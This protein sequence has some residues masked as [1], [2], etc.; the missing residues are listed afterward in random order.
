M[1]SP[2]FNIDFDPLL[3]DGDT[4]T[5]RGAGLS[6]DGLNIR[7]VSVG[8]MPEYAEDY[9]ALTAT[10]WLE[11]QQDTNLEMNPM[12]LSQLRMRVMFDGKVRLKNSPAV[13][14]WRTMR[15]I[16]YL[17]QWSEEWPDAVA[18]FYWRASEFFVYSNNIPSTSLYSDRT[19]TVSVVLYMGWRF[20]L[21]EIKEKGKFDIWISDWPSKIP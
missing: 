6:E 8:A 13:Q 4:A 11:D 12:E 9:G 20:R 18:N 16:F 17:P 5:L 14:Q 19:Q 1:G 15:T 10:V 7:C 3:L 2:R 21:Q